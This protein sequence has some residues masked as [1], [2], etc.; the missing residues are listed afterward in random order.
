MCLMFSGLK[1]MKCS[2]RAG[3]AAL[4]LWN[5]FVGRNASHSHHNQEQQISELEAS[6][7]MIGWHG[8]SN[9][10]SQASD[11]QETLPTHFVQKNA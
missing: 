4:F 8:G 11:T 2:V 1:R 10:K 7:W 6:D 9:I 3:S 5:R